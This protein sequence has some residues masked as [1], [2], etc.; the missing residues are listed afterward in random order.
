MKRIL[1]LGGVAAMILTIIAL[2]VAAV[3]TSS[4]STDPGP[5]SKTFSFIAKANSKTS[6]VV[7]NI[8]GL[9]INAR[10]NGSG[11]PVIF[12]F[13]SVKNGDLFGRMFD[14]LGRLHLIKNSSFTSSSKGVQ[15]S[16]NSG[17]FDATGTVLFESSN[18]KTV[19][20]NYAFDNAT[21]LAKSN[22]CTVY[23]SFI[24]S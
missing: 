12:A 13:S 6:N 2:V 9:T 14:G 3:G 10:C 11:E 8:D 17:D 4:A 22:V 18:G 15:L 23:G 16:A 5:V 1:G 7:S 20:F 21:T 24:A 19:T